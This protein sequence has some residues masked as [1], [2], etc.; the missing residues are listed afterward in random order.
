[1]GH[2]KVRMATLLNKFRI[3]F[4][5]V[6]I[7]VGLDDNPS[8]E[9]FHFFTHLIRWKMDLF[10]ISFLYQ[11]MQDSLSSSE[12]LETLYFTDLETFL[13]YTLHKLS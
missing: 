1:M 9:R 4:T 6:E 2:E 7:V 12:K 3:E 13:L 11:V 10:L 5:S 8:Q